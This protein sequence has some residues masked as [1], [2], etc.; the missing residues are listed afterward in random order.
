MNKALTFRMGLQHGQRCIS[1]LLEHL[2]KGELTSSFMLTHKMSLDEGMTGYDLFKNAG[3]FCSAIAGLTPC[4]ADGP[5]CKES[6]LN[7]AAI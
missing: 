5:P 2:Q 7:H 3:C 6:I 4:K 1:R